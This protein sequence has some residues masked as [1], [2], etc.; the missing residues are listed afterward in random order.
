MRRTQLINFFSCI[1]IL[2]LLQTI[3]ATVGEGKIYID[4]NSPG[5]RRLPLAVVNVSPEDAKGCVDTSIAK[6]GV[7]VL[8]QDLDL[9]GIAQILSAETFLIAQKDVRLYPEPIDY[10]AWSL[11]GAEALILVQISCNG[12]ELLMEGQLFD[13]LQ[14]KLIVSKKYQSQRSRVRAVAHK[15]AD[16]VLEYLTG[17]RGAF[18]SRIAYISDSSGFKELYVMDCDGYG[19]KRLTNLRSISML[20]SWSPKGDQIAFTSYCRRYPGIYFIDLNKPRIY[21]FLMGF[22]NL[23]TGATWSPKA[24]EIAFCAAIKGNTEI[25]VVN[26][27]EIKPVR[28][29]DNWSIDVSPSWSPDGKQIVFVSD[30]GGHPDLYML[31]VGSRNV[32]RLTFEG[33][34]NADP[35]WSPIGDW[36]AYASKVNS[37]FQIFRIRPDGKDPVQLTFSPEDCVNPTWSPDGRLIAYS[38]RKEGKHNIY[39]IRIDGTGEHR[40]T[41]D[42]H[43][44]TDP[45]WSPLLI[46]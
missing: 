31:G 7:E 33:N 46:E 21:Q 10:K 14:G 34:Y 3:P 23:M 37:I 32:S 20:P 25:F 1:L 36:I 13:V 38:T 24:N 39:L 43:N 26:L 12:E 40:I 28:L 5:F 2:F 18:E 4:I 42:R 30:R 45:A 15:F 9:S 6:E 35:A 17:R 44:N 16:E 11:I 27:S 41:Q 29:T 22:S 19:P 8:S